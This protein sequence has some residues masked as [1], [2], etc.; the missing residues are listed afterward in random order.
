VPRPRLI[1]S[2]GIEAYEIEDATGAT[3]PVATTY[4]AGDRVT[5]DRRAVVNGVEH[6]R[7]ADGPHAGRWIAYANLA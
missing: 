4:R 7:L 1:G 3:R 2:G 5:V 6:A